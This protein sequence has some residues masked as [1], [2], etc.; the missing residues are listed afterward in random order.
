[1]IEGARPSRPGLVSPDA[2]FPQGR[3]CAATIDRWNDREFDPQHS[4]KTGGVLLP[5]DTRPGRREGELLPKDLAH[6]LAGCRADD[7]LLR[8]RMRVLFK[9]QAASSERDRSGP[10]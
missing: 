3:E 7:E 8:P 1:M 10:S 9:D 6:T 4:V 5:L 2:P